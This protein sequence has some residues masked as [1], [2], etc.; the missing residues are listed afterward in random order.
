MQVCGRIKK[1][2][3]SYNFNHPTILHKHSLITRLLVL[4]VRTD[5]SHAGPHTMLSILTEDFYIVRV[6]LY[7]RHRFS[8][9]WD[10][11]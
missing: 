4:Q 11:L 6:I 9:C 7:W 10:L 1:S 8:T 5:A 2:E 3:Q